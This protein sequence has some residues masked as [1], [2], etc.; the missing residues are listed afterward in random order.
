M[1]WFFKKLGSL[2]ALRNSKLQIAKK[3]SRLDRRD[4]RQGGG[5]CVYCKSHLDCLVEVCHSEVAERSWMYLHS[6]HGIILIGNCYRPP[7]ADDICITSLPD[8]IN[9]HLPHVNGIVL[10]GDF[11]IHHRKWLRFSSGN[12]ALGETLK[13]IC[14][15]FTLNQL[16]SEPTR[17]QYLLD[18]VL[19]DMPLH[20]K[21]LPMIADH[22]SVFIKIPVDVAPPQTVS[23]HGWIYKQ[24][25]WQALKRDLASTNWQFVHTET[26]DVAVEQFTLTILAAA[27][28]HIPTRV[29]QEFKGK[30][31]WMNQV[32]REAIALKH[33]HEN[34]AD[35]AHFR[36]QCS[37]VLAKEYH[38]Y[39]AR[40]RADM[41]N[42]S[43][44]SKQWWKLNSILLH[45]HA[46]SS[47]VSALRSEG[48]WFL[49][50]ADKAN[51][52]AVTW[53]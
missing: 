44:Q 15:D 47:S 46:K 26:L 34:M 36:D 38:E 51:L 39:I 14:D 6:D 43:R 16:V 3:V 11:N 29:F 37:E 41:L 32:C 35:Y 40:T 4:G 31:P 23:R 10:I 12:T 25:H 42:C 21:V 5:I 45:R 50:P 28:A 30:H 53:K 48:E 20:V 2:R 9:Q 27:R 18:L 7:D 24:A 8:E 19:S 49:N 22:K 1:F 17:Q 52:F 33:S 13:G